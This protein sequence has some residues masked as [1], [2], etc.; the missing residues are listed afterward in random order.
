M[1]MR[2]EAMQQHNHNLNLSLSLYLREDAV[3]DH[4][5]RRI[6][7]SPVHYHLQ[8]KLQLTITTTRKMGSISVLWTITILCLC[9]CKSWTADAAA[10]NDQYA[11]ARLVRTESGH[12]TAL[13]LYQALLRENPD[14]LTTATRLAAAADTPAR[15]DAACRL[16]PTAATIV[17]SSSVSSNDLTLLDQKA[18]ELRHLLWKCNYHLYTIQ[19]LLGISNTHKLYHSSCPIYVTPSMAGASTRYPW[20]PNDHHDEPLESPPTA[21]QCLTALFLLGLAVPRETLLQSVSPQ[22][23][24]VDLQLLQDLGLLYP[25][26]TNPEL[27]LAH[28]QIFPL[29]LNKNN[30]DKNKNTNIP[31]T[32]YLV[33]D[34]HP[35]VLSSTTAGTHDAVMYI[36][37][38]SLALVQHWLCYYQQRAT[39]PAT[40]T[41]PTTVVVDICTGSG[42]Q[43][44]SAL[45][46]LGPTAQAVCVDINPRALRFAA[47]NAALNGLQDR[48]QYILGD[49]LSDEGQMWVPPREQLSATTLAITTATAIANMTHDLSE[50]ELPESVF[51]AHDRPLLEVLRE[52][53]AA[54]TESL[55]TA[56]PPHVIGFDGNTPILLE[57]KTSMLIMANPPFLPVP[58]EIVQARHGLFSAGG[59]SGESVLASIV[60][61]ASQLL[62]ENGYL[63][64][65]SEFFLQ[66]EDEEDNDDDDTDDA[67]NDSSNIDDADHDDASKDESSTTVESVPSTSTAATALLDRMKTWWGPV[68]GRGLLLTNQF[69]VSAT[70]YAER[71]ADSPHEERVWFQHLQDLDIAAASP[72]FLYIQ[73]L[74]TAANKD[75]KHLGDSVGENKN[76]NENDKDN[77]V[78]DDDDDGVL[79]LQHVKVP[80]SKWGSIWTPSNPAG[81]EFTQSVC[82][83]VFCRQYKKDDTNETVE[84]SGTDDS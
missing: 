2:S 35:R 6:Q 25:C 29:S 55:V 43:A 64:V 52:A 19:S 37:P 9:Y 24:P 80:K 40:S 81:V 77:G 54:A 79:E 53:I 45:A 20:Q 83:S 84:G 27:L 51:E 56:K 73:K 46:M 69:P 65:V 63:A 31:N 30:V 22:L 60:H 47:F 13:P 67:T 71:R 61:L 3:N 74:T 48:V 58:P 18:V 42:I 62:P 39:T 50:S 44:L 7:R 21:V 11:R 8:V 15:H 16:A 82:P 49:V 1:R 12:E 68:A 72:G 28:V 36:G 32:L 41:P 59:P 26:P 33:T 76:D 38:D 57:E 75:N 14:D 4:C 5:D 78:G 23:R 66:Q 17:S 10:T 34:W 70:T